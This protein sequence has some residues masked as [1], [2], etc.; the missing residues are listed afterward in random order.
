[1][2]VPEILNVPPVE[3]IEH[4][5]AKGYHIG[6]DWRDT[7]AANHIRSF[8]VA[9]A[10]ET[11]ILV[12]IR[13]AVDAAVRDGETF[14]DFRN[15]LEPFL[16]SKGWWGRKPMVDPQDPPRLVQLG[17]ARR[18]RTI[19]ETN[20]RMSYAH[21]RWQ[22][23]QRVKDTRPYLRYVSVLD[24]RT[25]PQHR[26]WHGTVLPVDHPFWE[27]HYPPNGWGCRCLVMQL[28]S[29]DL[30][31]YGFQVSQGP[32][33]GSLETRPWYNKRTETTVQVPRGI[34]PGFQHNVGRHMPGRDASNR[35][36]Q[37]IDGAPEDLP[38]IGQ[39]WNTPEFQ[40]HLDG[41]A[42]DRRA[43]W[44]IAVVPSRILDILG[45]RSRTLRLTRDTADKQGGRVPGNPGHDV[46]PEDYAR[47]QRILDDGEFFQDSDLSAV[48]F[49]EDENG[50]LWA[51]A[52]KVSVDRGETYLT[53]LHRA[54]LR[55]LRV[56]RRRLGG[57]YIPARP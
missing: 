10:M 32:P 25:R 22:R 49:M 46:A 20:L 14:E 34:D 24:G 40:G 6:F 11:D 57:R 17:S 4:F 19:F 9:K 37:K 47:A 35:L 33:A 54:Q 1:M 56:A 42:D 13:G 5:E 12:E 45:G 15:R 21:G 30:E 39:P 43:A 53:S 44:P 26:A 55:D 8:T 27:T 36:I 52:L 23:I 38:L 51:L 28:S 29:D 16:H 31:R 18:L 7:E 2:A 41:K 50:K 48:G 3:A